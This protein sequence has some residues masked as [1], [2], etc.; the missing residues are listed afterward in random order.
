MISF[1]HSQHG[2]DSDATSPASTWAV[3]GANLLPLLGVLM[4]GW[5]AFSVVALYWAENVTIGVINVLKMIACC[6]EASPGASDNAAQIDPSDADQRDATQRE[7]LS[8]SLAEMQQTLGNGAHAAKLFLIPFFI[9]HFGMFCLVHGVFVFVLLGDDDRFGVGLSPH[10]VWQKLSN[11]GLWWA[12]A[13]LAAG[14]LTSFFLDYLGKGEY[15]RT[16]LIALMMQPYGRIVLL[17]IT[18]LAG[19][20]LIA[21]LNSPR[22][23]L[24]LFVL[25]KTA[26]ELKLQGVRLPG[27]PTQTNHS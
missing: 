26:A 9:V 13:A 17:H 4:L 15:R 11:E 19:G 24:A 16:S 23:L 27:V 2:R 14:H 3:I 8:A 18:L 12:V 25:A 1:F 22:L 5:S 20:F 7:Q 6:P 10:A 21:F